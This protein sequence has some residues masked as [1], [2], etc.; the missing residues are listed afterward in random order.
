MKSAI[1]TMI[2]MIVMAMLALVG[3]SYLI[4]SINSATAQKFHSSVV[5]EIEA[6]DFSPVVIEKCEKRAK[7]NGYNS[8]AITTLETV[9]GE[10]YA[11]IV[12]D[13][14]YAVPL[15]NQVMDHTITGYAR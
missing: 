15:L 12:L 10:E 7:E 11:E 14:K 1:E 9:N 6:S 3:T 2:G 4:A 13:Y 5:Q 8:L